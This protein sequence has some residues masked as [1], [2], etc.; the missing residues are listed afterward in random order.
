MKVSPLSRRARCVSE[1]VKREERL[2]TLEGE[3]H[4]RSG[5]GG[6]SGWTC[7]FSVNLVAGTSC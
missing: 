4:P 6:V 1:G 3:S 7:G 2:R 5:G